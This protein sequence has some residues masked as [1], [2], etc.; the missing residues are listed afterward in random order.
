M[1][2]RTDV[3]FDSHGTTCAAWLYRPDGFEGPR[4]VIVLGHGLGAVKEM[5]LDAYASRFTAAGFICLVFDYRHFGGSGGEPRQL[6]DI[7]RQLEDW[8]E[9]IDFAKS[10]AGAD[11][12]RIGLFGTSF[13]GGH[14]IVTAANHP[15][16]GA[17]V[18]QCPFTSGSA[19]SRTL[20]ILGLAKVSALA[21]ADLAAAA[22]HADPVM[23]PLAGKPGSAALMNAADVIPGYLGLVPD[24]L[25]FTN[26]V[27]AR[28]GAAIT[29]HHPGRRAKD[30]KCPI[31]FSVCDK[32]SVAPPGPTMKYAALAPKG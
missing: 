25:D 18:S 1:P 26:A 23:V 29:L 24:G 10:I 32:D 31:M 14:V 4:P 2:T 7:D 16:V 30:V 17:V 3:T 22:A 28:V 6:L 27:A 20:G 12:T 8:S 13:G 9:A 19:S 15:E 11:P 5:G 21:T